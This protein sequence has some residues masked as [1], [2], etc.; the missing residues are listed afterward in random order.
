ML[1]GK[2]NK[3]LLIVSLCCLLVFMGIGYALLYTRL[4][5]S[6]GAN[7]SGIWN[8]EIVDMKITSKKGMAEEIEYN[9]DGLTATFSHKLYAP[10]DSIEYEITIQN[11]GNIKASLNQITSTISQPY[12]NLLLSNTLS[13][14]QVIDG[15]EKIK[16]TIKSE[17]DIRATRLP[18]GVIEPKYHIE[19]LLSQYEGGEFVTPPDMETDNVCF[20]VSNSG[21]L[22]DY[23]YEKCGSTMTVPES[24]NGIKVTKISEKVFDGNK[25]NQYIKSLGYLRKKNLSIFTPNA[26]TWD[27]HFYETEEDKNSYLTINNLDEIDEYINYRIHIVTDLTSVDDYEILIPDYIIPINDEGFD[28]WTSEETTNIVYSYFWDGG[29]AIVV[30]EEKDREVGILFAENFWGEPPESVY[31][32]GV[33]DIPFKYSAKVSEVRYNDNVSIYYD[34]RNWLGMYGKK[35]IDTLDL[36]N[37]KY[38]TE[39]DFKYLDVNNV[40]FPESLTKISA[41]A[42]SNC[43]FTYINIPKNVTFIGDYAFNSMPG[44]SLI[45]VNRPKNGMTLGT[46]WNGLAS[47]SYS[48]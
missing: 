3:M 11:K 47:V 32:L 17:F 14:G 39:I 36:S 15:G 5:V 30:L 24:V 48:S 18:D 19:I 33:D 40:L 20:V 8:I 1:R 23:D 46:K 31:V 10:G 25:Y 35:I 7:M 12:N 4:D 28:V 29:I 42:F 16:F 37:A 9:Y 38:L 44:G 22:L 26:M 13:Q 6:G 21:E 2:K 34:N 27:V 45:K 41:S 43:K